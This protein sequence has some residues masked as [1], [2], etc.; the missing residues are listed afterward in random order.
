MEDPST[1]GATASHLESLSHQDNDTT[2]Q[3]K[4]PGLEPIDSTQDDSHSHDDSAEFVPGRKRKQSPSTGDNIDVYPSNEPFP[5]GNPDGYKFIDC[6]NLERIKRPRLD[7]DKANSDKSLLPMEIW[8]HIFSIL[9]P[10]TLG[11]LLRVNKSFNSFLASGQ[12]GPTEKSSS[13]CGILRPVSADYIWASARKS[14]YPGMPRPLA[15]MT[16]LDMWKLIGATT[17]QSCGKKDLN[18]QLPATNVQPWER[19]PGTN[20]VRIF[21]P[22]RIRTCSKCFL[23]KTQK[24]RLPTDWSL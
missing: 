24:V 6:D 1:T 3:T 5:K 21:W 14:C 23:E 16:E 11:A 17:C 4:T 2:S 9:D 10:K 15:N 8:H 19:G 18:T 20:G 7:H 12:T 13:A 22:F